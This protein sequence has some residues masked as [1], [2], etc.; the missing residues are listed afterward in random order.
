ML[1]SL[2]AGWPKYSQE[3]ELNG[4]GQHKW[5]KLNR[6]EDVQKLKLERTDQKS[7]PF[8]QLNLLFRIGSESLCSWEHAASSY[9]QN[10]KEGDSYTLPAQASPQAFSTS[11]RLT[12]WLGSIV[13]QHWNPAHKTQCGFTLM[14]RYMPSQSASGKLN[15]VAA[16]VHVAKLPFVQHQPPWLHMKWQL[17][18]FSFQALMLKRPFLPLHPEQR[19]QN[20]HLQVWVGTSLCLNLVYALLPEAEQIFLRPTSS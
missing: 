2:S 19:P 6:R 5:F 7:V 3:T 1:I 13:T 11:S 8:L 20:N 14:V 15:W 10:G 9:G 16:S 17:D 18:T 12:E 4:T